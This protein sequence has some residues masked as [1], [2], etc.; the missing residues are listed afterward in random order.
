MGKR[1]MVLE[2]QGTRKRGGPKQ[3]W[4]DIIKDMKVKGSRREQT[5][6]GA[7]WRRLV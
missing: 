6:D 2:V 1:V 3:R 7:M 5:Q 4:M